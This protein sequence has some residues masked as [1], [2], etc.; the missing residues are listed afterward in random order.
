M[1]WPDF[2][3]DINVLKLQGT[4]DVFLDLVN[5]VNERLLTIN[6]SPIDTNIRLRTL[7]GLA[8]EIDNALF[9]TLLYDPSYRYGGYQQ[10]FVNHTYNS[11]DYHNHS[12]SDIYWTVSRLLDYLGDDSL[13]SILNS[14]HEYCWQRYRILNLYRWMHSFVDETFIFGNDDASMPFVHLLWCYDNYGEPTSMLFRE[15]LH[16]FV[17]FAG[18]NWSNIQSYIDNDPWTDFSNNEH[19]SD[20]N[21]VFPVMFYD[22][23]GYGLKWSDTYG[24][25]NEAHT[26]A[27]QCKATFKKKDTAPFDFDA[28]IY[29]SANAPE[30][31]VFLP[32]DQ[33]A[34]GEGYLTKCG[35]LSSS[36][37]EKEVKIW[38]DDF[39]TGS[40][41]SEPDRVVA[42][43]G[44]D[45]NWFL[46]HSIGGWHWIVC[47][48]QFSYN[49]WIE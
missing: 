4:Y 46:G 31:A 35:E 3:S 45:P 30:Y 24:W 49:D 41:F 6:Q 12:I 37:T 36:E 18:T 27:L 1:G 7:K 32:N 8:T 39:Y 48:P 21:G 9:T 34:A 42:P 17:N 16:K 23:E 33:D 13:F 43:P 15:K 26:L 19:M 5:A 25:E 10:F 22:A 44:W 20:G 47:K 2:W 29:A 14:T 28:D 11:G 40:K 38:D